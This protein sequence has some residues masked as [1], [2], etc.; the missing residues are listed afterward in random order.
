MIFKLVIKYSLMQVKVNKLVLQGNYSACW[1]KIILNFGQI[2]DGN[3]V[4]TDAV[5]TPKLVSK[6]K[7]CQCSGKLDDAVLAWRSVTGLVRGSQ[8]AGLGQVQVRI[9]T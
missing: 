4:L 6:R 5:H 1:H 8:A 2:N 7:L 3:T 9:I